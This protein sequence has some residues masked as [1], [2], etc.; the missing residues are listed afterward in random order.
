VNAHAAYIGLGSNVGS[1]AVNLARAVAE[2]ERIGRVAQRSSTYRTVPWGR[3]DQREFFNAVVLLETALPP[4]DLLA[5]LGT[6][7]RRLGR[8]AGERWGPRV[9]DLDLLL[10]DDLTIEEEALRV[11]HPHLGERAFVLVPLAELDARFAATRD[12]LK[13][14]ELAGVTPV[15][16]ESR[17]AMTSK[18]SALVAQR[19]RAL[20]SFLRESDAVRARI[21]CGDDEIEVA[22][23]ARIAPQTARERDGQSGEMP[24]ARVD[25]VKADLV[26]IFHFSRPA[27]AEG[28]ILENDHELGYIEAL[29]IRTPVRSMGAGRL[30]AI[31][32]DDDSPVE[33]GQPLFA[34]SRG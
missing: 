6:I 15:A 4:H 21:V 5:A 32:A 12:A 24:P 22:R 16:D 17:T 1:R 19:V 29:G 31:T 33:Y 23:G 2:L 14:A 10:Y 34:I 25:T 26:G 9:I 13:P 27:P 3:R 11:P 28:E 20:A 8:T 7:E 18:A 30:V